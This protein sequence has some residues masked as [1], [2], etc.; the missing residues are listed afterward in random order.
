MAEHTAE[1]RI[2]VTLDERRLAES[3]EWLASDAGMP[4]PQPAGAFL[5][6]V[7]D[8]RERDSLG[9]DLWTKQFPVDEMRHLVGQTLM[10]LGDVLGR[11]TK[12]ED[13]GHRVSALGHELLNSPTRSSDPA[14]DEPKQ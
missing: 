1:I 5:L 2:K 12:D 9:I 11:A 14:G 6:S 3:I 7:W 8:P 4:G 10:R 13:A